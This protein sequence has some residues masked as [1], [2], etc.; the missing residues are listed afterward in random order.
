MTKRISSLAALSLSLGLTSCGG[1]GGGGGG[2]GTTATTAGGGTIDP[3]TPVSTETAQDVNNIIV[4][5]SAGTLALDSNISIIPSSDPGASLVWS[6][7]TSDFADFKADTFTWEPS[8]QPMKMLN[9][10]MCVF[11][12]TGYHLYANEGP[13]LAKV[14]MDDCFRSEGAGGAAATPAAGGQGGQSNS[15]QPISVTVQSIKEEGKPLI[16]SVWFTK[17]GDDQMYLPGFNMYAQVTIAEPMSD[18]NPFGIFNLKWQ[19]LKVDGSTETEQESMYGYIDVGRQDDG[20]VLL[21]FRGTD[22][23]GDSFSTWSVSNEAVAILTVD[24]N[25]T[26]ADRITAGLARTAQSYA[27]SFNDGTDTGASN[28]S[29]DQSG[30]YAIAFDKERIVTQ[31]SKA[32]GNNYYYPE[33][34]NPEAPTCR[35]RNENYANIYSYAFFKADGSRLRHQTGYP[36]VTDKVD[37]WGWPISGWV[38]SWGLYLYGVNSGETVWLQDNAGNKTPYTFVTLKGTL[39]DDMWQSVTISAPSMTLTCTS[40]CLKASISA[41]DASSYTTTM[42]GGPY[43]YSWDATTKELKYNGT[44]VS[45]QSDVTNGW[46]SM[47]LTD[48]SGNTYQYEMNKSEW[49][50]AGALKNPD[51]GAFFQPPGPIEFSPFVYN[52]ARDAYPGNSNTNAEGKT[53]NLTYDGWS[54]QGID[55]ANTGRKDQFGWEMWG[56]EVAL[57]KGTTLTVGSTV[58]GVVNAGDE[59]RIAPAWVELQPKIV[60]DCSEKLYELA[61][62][63]PSM[64]DLPDELTEDER[65]MKG[66]IGTRPTQSSDGGD[67]LTRVK[68]GDAL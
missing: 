50:Q 26:G 16:A 25:A 32:E 58:S 40:S 60:T 11:S 62:S 3:G 8:Q 48:S 39:R 67:L 52:D 64:M 1:G 7:A 33:G 15:S 28:S 46:A 6:L 37:D 30:S 21:K 47:S 17:E 2:G 35:T 23:F 14:S 29:S 42:D 65:N 53:F 45:F 24:T 19:A 38:D 5:A 54:L 55:W 43:Q 51:T 4:S 31:Y 9:N 57:K 36:I 56:P 59:I 66:A 12:R 22:A 10:I 18:E 20:N 49:S 68:D 27:W 13:F 61:D 34:I 44:A 63:A 41:A